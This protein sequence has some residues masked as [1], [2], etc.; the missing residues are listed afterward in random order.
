[1]K[2]LGPSSVSACHPCMFLEGSV[3]LGLQRR[4]QLKSGDGEVTP[5]Q[6]DMLTFLLFLASLYLCPIPVF[7]LLVYFLSACALSTSLPGSRL[8]CVLLQGTSLFSELSEL[9]LCKALGEERH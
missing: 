3:S 2:G 6:L 7:M 8:A 9:G 5:A 4:R 1:M